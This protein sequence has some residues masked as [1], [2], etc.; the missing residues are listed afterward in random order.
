MTKETQPSSIPKTSAHEPKEYFQSK[1]LKLTRARKLIVEKIL[2]AKVG[3]HFSADQL[4]ESLRKKDKRVSKATIYRTLNLLAEKK[5][6]EEHD[7]GREEK[8]YERMVERPHHDHLI[9]VQCGRI[10]EFENPEIE[11]LQE[12]IARKENFKISYHNHK[13]FGSCRQCRR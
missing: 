10:I 7:F 2:S 9:C 5:I 1:D 6:V 8:Y 13:I 11:R 3:E 12:D 4:L